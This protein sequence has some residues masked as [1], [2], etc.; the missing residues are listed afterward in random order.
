MRTK[1]IGNSKCLL[2]ALLLLATVTVQADPQTLVYASDGSSQVWTGLDGFYAYSLT[3]R[4]AASG[5]S[6]IWIIPFDD[7][8][9]SSLA[10]SAPGVSSGPRLFTGETLR[11]VD[12]DYVSG[13]TFGVSPNSFEQFLISDDGSMVTRVSK[14]ALLNNKITILQKEPTS[15]FSH[16]I[17]SDGRFKKIDHTS[18]AVLTLDTE[19]R[20]G[21]YL[22]TLRS[23]WNMATKYA[24]GY[25]NSV[26]H[27]D[28]NNGSLLSRLNFP[29]MTVDHLLTDSFSSD[30]IV[31]FEN[32]T[33]HKY[34]HTGG[35][36]TKVMSIPASIANFVSGRRFTNM[37][38]F[39]P[40]QI[41]LVTQFK[42]FAFFDLTTP[43]AAEFRLVLQTTYFYN[44]EI[45]S[46]SVSNR[47]LSVSGN[48]FAMFDN[49]YEGSRWANVLFFTGSMPIPNCTTQSGSSCTACEALHYSRVDVVPNQCLLKA[50]IP[51]GYG[52]VTGT[53]KI[54]PCTLSG[55]AA[56]VEDKAVCSSCK[57]SRWNKAGSS[58][59]DCFSDQTIPD[60]WGKNPD[61]NSRNL[62]ACQVADCQKCPEKKQQCMLCNSGKFLDAD[63][64]TTCSSSIPPGKFAVTGL[65]TSVSTCKTRGCLSCAGDGTGCTQCDKVNGY[66]LKGTN[67]LTGDAIPNGEGKHLM[68][69]R[70][71]P[72]T[73]R[74]P[75]CT[76]CRENSLVCTSCKDNFYLL[77]GICI[78]TPSI[79]KGYG[80][81]IWTRTLERCQDPNCDNCD[82]DY[83]TCKT[84]EPGSTL[85]NGTCVLNCT[86]GGCTSCSSVSGET[87]CVECDAANDYWLQTSDG[88]CLLGS[89]I[90][91]G[92][93]KNRLTGR[94]E[95]CKAGCLECQHDSS[96]CSVCD[97]SMNLWSGLNSVCLKTEDIPM[98]FGKDSALGKLIRCF[99]SNC[100][101]CREDPFDC[102][103]C[104]QGMTL[105]KETSNC[106]ACSVK[107]CSYCSA[108]D[109][110]K[111]QSCNIGFALENG[112]CQAKAS[113]A[114]ASL[115]MTAT[116]SFLFAVICFL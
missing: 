70:V 102:K 4:E 106:L 62:E 112:S 6:A 111:C 41:F 12:Y 66:W 23:A 9:V 107:D 84:C 40:F 90:P 101:D 60:G 113:G 33:G 46:R 88:T 45:V 91:K 71:E 29:G 26:F 11:S 65:P 14:Q 116:L 59:L 97:K 2:I 19:V 58:T 47:A 89:S 24:S 95:D 50:N 53:M 1:N 114:G 13:L 28:Q 96:T 20:G 31:A 32:G 72:C 109:S 39:S 85:N 16:G 63:T 22:H 64:F 36:A 76:E 68:T 49:S 15:N 61:N 5:V 75:D 79:Q 100:E 44:E 99:S 73:D 82:Q 80:P 57:S 30:V 27:L 78:T 104:P 83:R 25:T 67:C 37:E 34:S 81:D 56:C 43:S 17:T 42:H 38:K 69:G 115:L 87:K 93:G 86:F 35:V 52:I 7:Y 48:R 94:V 3:Q 77:N 110:K 8:L 92:K 105:N 98:G 103:R 18:T 10:A 55:C 51:T 108:M 74:T 21:I 54:E